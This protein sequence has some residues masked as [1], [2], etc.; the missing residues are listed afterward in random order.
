MTGSVPSPRKNDVE[1]DDVKKEK[2]NKDD[3][4]R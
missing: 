4:D 1:A 3:H 2:E